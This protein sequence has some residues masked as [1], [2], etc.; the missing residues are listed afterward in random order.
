MLLDISSMTY[1]EPNRP[2]AEWVWQA[3]GRA[4]PPA[5]FPAPAEGKSDIRQSGSLRSNA[6]GQRNPPQPLAL[7]CLYAPEPHRYPSVAPLIIYERCY[8]GVT[9]G[10]RR[11]Y[12]AVVAA[13]GW[14][15]T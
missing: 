7:L 13:S 2:S 4:W 10:M 8:G 3:H 15:A 1:P 9:V 14:E 6:L 11:G 12:G 5:P